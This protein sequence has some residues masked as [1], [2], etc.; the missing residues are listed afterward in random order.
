MGALGPKGRGG[1]G[2][3]LFDDK[4]RVEN[5]SNWIANIYSLL[6]LSLVTLKEY[7]SSS[8]L[9]YWYLTETP[10]LEWVPGPKGKCRKDLLQG[11]SNCTEKRITTPLRSR[12]GDTQI[13]T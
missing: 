3:S 8:A 2:N 11:K 9:S 12:A 6:A 5:L 4:L 10:C 1:V 13:V 7:F